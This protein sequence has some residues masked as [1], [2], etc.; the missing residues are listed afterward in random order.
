MDKLP[1]RLY[2]RDTYIERIKP[3]MRTPIVKVMIGHRRVGK[4]YLLF[5]LIELIKKEEKDA[6]IIYINKEDIEFVDMVTFKELYSYIAE[7]LSNEKK[8]Y[9]FI[10]EIQEIENFKTVVRSLAL[11]ENNDIYI[12]GSNSHMFSSDLANELGGRY[13][14]FKIYSLSYVEFLQFHNFSDDDK[15]LEK[16]VHFG[17]LPYL[18]HLPMNDAII[19]EYIKSIYST[20][21]L[22]DVIERNK[23][24]NISFLDQLIRFLANNV[25][26]LF[27]SKSISDF[28][29][30]QNIKMSPT[31]VSEYA[32]SLTDAFVLNRATRYDIVGKKFFE[33]GEKYFFE[34]MGI[35]NAIAGYTPQ[36]RAKR[37]E[38]IVYNHLL[39]CGYDVK[40]GT[41]ATEEIDFVCTR[42]GETIYVQVAIELSK[43]ETITREFGNLLKIK[44]NYPK[45]VVSGEYSFE[46]SFEGVEHIY[47]RNFLTSS[48][49]PKIM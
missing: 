39:F 35:R 28:L 41:L 16:Y 9:I 37:L 2:C 24:R 48:I 14:E 26:S 43:P 3:F 5:Q 22:R 20:I 34:N 23:I 36:D 27:S 10:D 4:S 32:D 21:V 33:R 12:T 29:K 7:R 6:N 19:M 49:T 45:I 31:L 44:D 11:D 1:K 13:V 40:V 46:N 25:G 30:S 47:I 38:N 18:I 15:S 8:N 17:G 42:G